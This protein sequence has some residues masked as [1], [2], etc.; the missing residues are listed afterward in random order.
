MAAT[1]TTVFSPPIG[2]VV[3][4][5]TETTVGTGAEAA[6]FESLEVGGVPFA[7]GRGTFTLN[8]ATPVAVPDTGALATSVYA[9]SLNTLGGTQGAQPVVTGVTAGT[10]FDVKGT[11]SDTSIYNWVRL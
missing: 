8:G 4:P 11:A 10:G 2:D 5:I 3:L 1:K 7:P 9:I 6:S